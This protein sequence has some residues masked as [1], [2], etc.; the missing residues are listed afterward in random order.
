MDH[1]LAHHKYTQVL[2]TGGKHREFVLTL[3]T[4]PDAW[5]HR[6]PQHGNCSDQLPTNIALSRLYPPKQSQHDEQ[7]YR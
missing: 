1:L 4:P 3:T 2:D 5:I 7:W 6:H